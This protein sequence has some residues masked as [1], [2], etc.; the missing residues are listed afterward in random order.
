M[1]DQDDGME[2]EMKANQAIGR[3]QQCLQVTTT[4]NDEW[5]DDVVVEREKK[6]KLSRLSLPVM[7]F[8]LSLHLHL[9]SLVT[10]VF[11]SVRENE[12]KYFNLTICHFWWIASVYPENEGKQIFGETCV[13][14]SLVDD[15]FERWDE[16]EK[17]LCNYNEWRE[18]CWE[19][20]SLFFI[21]S[22][23]NK[24]LKKQQSKVFHLHPLNFSQFHLSS[25]V[26]LTWILDFV[27][28]FLRKILN[29]R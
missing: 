15:L 16:R 8:S 7:S 10:G 13:D 18:W 1:H 20:E 17:F 9:S 6:I 19:L 21:F 29:P 23:R 24:Q 27:W 22:M 14:H 25:L 26:V 11:L 2:K 5:S 28:K 3:L 12:R 4:Y